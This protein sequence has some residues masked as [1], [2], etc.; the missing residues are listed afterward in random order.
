MYGFKNEPIGFDSPIVLQSKAP[1]LNTQD[2]HVE[3]DIFEIM[4][5][6]KIAEHVPPDTPLIHGLLCQKHKM[7]IYGPSK[8]GKSFIS[9][10]LAV[11]LASGSDWLGFPCEKCKVLIIELENGPYATMERIEHICEKSG[12]DKTCMKNIY[13]LRLKSFPEIAALREALARSIKSDFYGAVIIDP[14]YSFLKG[15]ENQADIVDAF[16]REIDGLAGT[17]N[18][19][20]IVCH[21]VR[22]AKEGSG[23]SIDMI[24]G[25]SIF[26]RYFQTLFGIVRVKK[27][28]YY[29]Q[30][31][32][33]IATRCFPPQPNL[34]VEFKD[35]IFTVCE[36]TDNEKA[37]PSAG[38]SKPA[39]NDKSTKL[40]KA[41]EKNKSEDGTA[42]ISDLVST[43]NVVRN[44][45]ISYIKQTPGFVLVGK[46]RVKYSP[47]T[48]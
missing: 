41:Y 35:G 44:T 16:I 48:E 5:S 15:N 20:L 28:N 2:F 27:R 4:P 25:S 8:S 45:V 11:S 37:T 18:S 31:T 36:K 39:R 14:A 17:L 24:S 46:G 34:S 19:S 29:L 30:E 7:L 22:K 26:G 12:I 47:Q 13:V 32:I 10:A 43:M 40:I 6:N 23:S 33:E 21:H 9:T 3:N 38:V 42:K 1:N